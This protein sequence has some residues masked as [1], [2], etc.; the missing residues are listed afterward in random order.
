MSSKYQNCIDACQKCF[1]DCQKC[2][3]QMVGQKSNNDCPNC[4]IQCVD[5]CLFTIK[6]MI[7]DSQFTAKQ[8]L[9]CAEICEWCASQCQEH[10]HEH[11]KACAESC[12]ACAKECRKLAA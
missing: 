8:V 4:C 3:V 2:I 6:L 1:I 12:L 9:L 10:D 7:A 5:A 11:C